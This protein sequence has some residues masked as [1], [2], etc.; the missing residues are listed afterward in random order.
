MRTLQ[1]VQGFAYNVQ[2]TEITTKW[3]ATIEDCRPFQESN[4]TRA[5]TQSPPQDGVSLCWP[6]MVWASCL[7]GSCRHL[8]HC[9]TRSR[10]RWPSAC[11]SIACP[12]SPWW[13]CSQSPRC[14]RT[15]TSP[16][17]RRPPG[18]TRCPANCGISANIC[19]RET[20][21]DNCDCSNR[22]LLHTKD[23]PGRSTWPRS[24]WPACSGSTARWPQRDT[25]RPDVFGVCTGHRHNGTAWDARLAGQL[26]L[27]Q[28]TTA[29][30]AI[31]TLHKCRAA[32]NVVRVRQCRRRVVGQQLRHK[33][34]WFSFNLNVARVDGCCHF[35]LFSAS[36]FSSLSTG[37]V[38]SWV[39]PSSQ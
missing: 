29:A 22:G 23:R 4:R 13:P 17:S 10:R 9:S 1:L 15:G 28:R 8:P 16:A 19:V 27:L 39:D 36:I 35:I 14:R 3:W 34:A 5:R 37:P 30:I 33:S 20:S 18:A 25:A 7:R 32:A 38:G 6:S 31:G 12:C 26:V 2:Q 24:S 11:R 21:L